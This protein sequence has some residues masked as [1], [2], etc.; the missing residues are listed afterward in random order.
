MRQSPWPSHWHRPMPKSVCVVGVCL[1]GVC[2]VGCYK[3]IRT[4]QEISHKMLQLI[5]AIPLHISFIPGSHEIHMIY[6]L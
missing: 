1:C 3:L 5:T 6:C 2:G 4:Q